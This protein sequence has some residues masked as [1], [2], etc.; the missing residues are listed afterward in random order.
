MAQRMTPE[1]EPPVE[2]PDAP[3]DVSVA[4]PG[5]EPVPHPAGLS[6]DDPSEPK[7]GIVPAPAQPR[8][9]GFFAALLGGVLAAV[10]GFG[11]SHYNV[12]GLSAP[13]QSGALAALDQRLTE[14][15]SA[16]RSDE[17]ALA[18]LRADLAAL[19]DRVAR[20]EAAPAPEPPDLSALDEL[21]RRIA[22]IEALPAGDG[23][24]STAALAAKL[25]DLE[26]Q[27]AAVPRGVDLADLQAALDRLSAAEAE[28]ESRAAEA[29]A[30]ARAAARA[31]ALDAL[32]AA[33][34]SGAD[35]QA[36]LAA[37]ADPGL[38]AVLAPYVSGASTLA[39]LQADFPEAA[40]QALQLAR[41]ASGGGGWAD[42]LVAFLAA[43]TGARS[44]APREGDDPDA[45]LSRAEFALSEGRLADALTELSSLDAAIRGPLDGWIAR[46]EARLAVDAALEGR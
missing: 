12:F 39:D 32:R 13:D 16:V 30:A 3:V 24:P 25:A 37:V 22:A 28:A 41:K 17:A 5:P 23:G 7:S 31:Q 4:E 36:E 15:L 29:A 19:S 46:A 35:F 44:L 18:S 2:A 20:L 6:G 40:R 43:Q 34:A 8:R 33:V 21:D 38:T 10:L 42:R 11:L 1:T 26:R 45:V 9:S 27:L 14:S